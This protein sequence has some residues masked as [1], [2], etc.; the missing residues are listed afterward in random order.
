MCD[1]FLHFLSLWTDL[2]VDDGR[3]RE[4]V[5]DLGAVPPHCDGAVLPQTL[6]VEAV[7]LSDLSGLVVPSDQRDSVRVAHLRG[8][9][10]NTSSATY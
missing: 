4:V 6:V 9:S 1:S 5:E 10:T 3:Q 7:H 8:S 2:A